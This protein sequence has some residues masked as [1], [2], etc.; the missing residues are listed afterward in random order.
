MPDISAY[1]KKD[2]SFDAAAYNAA[3]REEREVRKQNGEL[4]SRCERFI[5]F[6]KAYPQTCDQCKSLQDPKEVSHDKEVRCPKCGHSWD[7]Y[8]HEDYKVLNDGTHDV[9]C[10]DCE[11]DF[12]VRTWVSHT[13]VSPAR[14]KEE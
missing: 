9:T 2:G 11:H 1:K 13:F 5:I 6:A 10:P 7:P 12:E 4:C 8:E 3:Y 14:I